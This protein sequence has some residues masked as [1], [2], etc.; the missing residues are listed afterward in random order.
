MKRRDF[1]GSILALSAQGLMLKAA[2]PNPQEMKMDMPRLASRK[3]AKFDDNLVVFISDL[4]TRDSGPEPIRQ[5]RAFEDILKMNPLPR[6]IIALGDL[7]HLYG[8]KEN[9]LLAKT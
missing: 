1:L 7:A 5:R 4:H 6:N 3:K 8:Y 2:T 9:Y